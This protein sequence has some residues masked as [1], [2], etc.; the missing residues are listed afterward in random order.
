MST[1]ADCYAAY[2]KAM[3]S[4]GVNEDEHAGEQ[5]YTENIRLLAHQLIVDQTQSVGEL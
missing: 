5:F 2:P 4:Y 3:I 1:V